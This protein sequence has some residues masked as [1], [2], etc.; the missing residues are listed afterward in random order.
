MFRLISFQANGKRVKN[1]AER[2]A[3]YGLVWNGHLIDYFN[4]V[5]AANL[6]R[7]SIELYLAAER[8]N[9]RTVSVRLA[10]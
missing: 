10:A 1:A 2:A 3:F 7:E 6:A 9:E 4:T 8:A 5:A